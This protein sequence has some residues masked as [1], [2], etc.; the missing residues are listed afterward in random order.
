MVLIEIL[1][2]IGALSLARLFTFIL[3]PAEN[4]EPIFG[5]YKRPGK[6]Y[7]AKYLAMFFILKSRKVSI[8][9]FLKVNMNKKI[10]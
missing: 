1:S 7:W 8:K 6:W 5:I 10:F 9:I 3:T 4:V 2:F